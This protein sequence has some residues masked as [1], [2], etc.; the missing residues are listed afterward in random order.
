MNNRFGIV[1]TLGF[2]QTLAWASTYYLPAILAVP[3]A[4][5]IGVAPSWIYA[6]LSLGL[7][8]SAFLGPS[9][10]RMIDRRGGRRVLCGSNVA[11]AVGLFMLGESTGPA[12]LVLAWLVLGVAMAAGLYEPAFAALTRLYGHDSRSAITGIT[13]IAGFA[14][15]V[16]W[17]LST[18]LE[19][20]FGWRGTCFSWAAL[21][22]AIGLP[23]NAWALRKAI[24]DGTA[25]QSEPVIESAEQKAT[26]A[27]A[28]VL[29]AFIFTTAGIVSI[30]MATNLPRLFSA[31]G[32]SPA[33]AIAAAS[34][35]GPA[36]VVAR[37]VEYSARRR[38]NPLV[39][40]KIASA[41]HPVAAIVLA[42]GGVPA[43]APFAIIHG[44]GNGMLTIVRGTLPLAL[45]GPSGY[46][47]RIGRISVPA[48]IGQAFAPFLIGLSIDRLGSDTLIISAGL[49]LAAFISLFGLS[50]PRTGA[51]VMRP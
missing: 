23:L 38:I 35:M 4:R 50:L 36:Q 7:S 30:G 24:D 17:P 15:T 12:S 45:F 18:L 48:R 20:S 25:M 31:V 2:T 27:R 39:S 34:L 10:G 28:M 51:V 32:A 44:A 49:Y 16:G 19:H 6:G 13:L 1:A 29:L 33:A 43:V 42:L 46:G 22:V 9:L 21:H 40:A 14:S 41:L 11:F 37:I 8:V 3:I 47:A 26:G 5:D